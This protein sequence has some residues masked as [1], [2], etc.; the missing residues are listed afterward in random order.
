[1]TIVEKLRKLNNIIES[2]DKRPEF[3]RYGQ[4]LWDEC[5]KAF[6]SDVE[7]LRSTKVDPYYE[8]KRSI[9]FVNALINIF[10]KGQVDQLVES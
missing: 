7:S 3:I 8:N 1:M 4:A 10:E 9:D 5:E 2:L 6:P